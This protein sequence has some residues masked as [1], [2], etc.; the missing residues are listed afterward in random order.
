MKKLL[1]AAILAMTPTV[2]MA[3]PPADNAPITREEVELRADICIG[4]YE[5]RYTGQQVVEALQLDTLRKRRD[6]AL[7]CEMMIY[8][9]E[10]VSANYEKGTT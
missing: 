3:A 9:I 10:V 6:F 4:L 8:T 7:Q 1:L 5:G 2:A